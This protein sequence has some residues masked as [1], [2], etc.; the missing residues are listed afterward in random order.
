MTSTSIAEALRLHKLAKSLGNE[1]VALSFFNQAVDLSFGIVKAG[2][3]ADRAFVLIQLGR[4]QEALDDFTESIALDSSDCN[5]FY[6]QAL[7][8]ASIGKYTEAKESQQQAISVAKL[9]SERNQRYDESARSQGYRNVAELYSSS[10]T[11]FVLSTSAARWRRLNGL[12][13]N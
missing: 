12:D 13:D 10:T 6:G 4:F 8:L 11:D 2:I 3:L 7:A 1:K 5:C 9:H